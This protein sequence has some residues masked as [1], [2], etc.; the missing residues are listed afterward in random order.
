[1]IH[2]ALILLTGALLTL[3]FA[4]FYIWPFAVVSPLIFFILL[5]RHKNLSGFLVTGLLYGIGFFATSVSWIYVSIHLFSQSPLLSIAITAVFVLVMSLFFMLFALIAYY[6]R[7][8]KLNRALTY[9]V[10]WTLLE[11]IRGHLFT[12]FPWV[13]IGYGF[14][15]TWFSGYAVIGSVYL[16]S[17][18]SV[19]ITTLLLALMAP[20]Q[21]LKT[22]LF[23]LFAIFVLTLIGFMLK[24]HNW[25]QKNSKALSVSLIQGDYV[26]SQKWNPEMLQ[27][28]IDYY[29]TATQD[30]PADLIFWSENAIPTYRPYISPFLRQINTL[31][32]SEDSA[33]L[34]GTIDVNS[35][36]QYFNA[37]LV[38][39]KGSGKYYKHH[40]VPF[41]EYYP[42]SRLIS[43]FMRYFNIPMSD[44]T[45]GEKIQPLLEMNGIS[46]ALFICYEIAYPKEVR[47][48]LQN[49]GLIAVISDDAWFGNSLAPWQHLEISQMRA[50]ENGRFVLQTTNNGITA[51]IDPKG[52]ITARLKPNTQDILHGK[53]YSYHGKTPWLYLG[54]IPLYCLMILFLVIAFAANKI[55]KARLK[56]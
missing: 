33:I 45:A 43:P 51:I 24:Q 12:G 19:F 55:A 6:T 17:F 38:Y 48:Q 29:Y 8:L 14:T 53:V 10:A 49:A 30:N 25:T 50:I 20:K 34:V 23:C 2:S 22:R 52:Q 21:S 15:D 47:D 4:P 3:S 26:L 44:F 40:L 37:A 46:V 18:I 35:K 36:N 42:F 31:G 5:S 28:I 1:M 39:G 32:N 11:L 9:P 7:T 54:M 13:L 27:T 41:A 56:P 16:V